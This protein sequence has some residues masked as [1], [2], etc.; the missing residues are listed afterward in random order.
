MESRFQPPERKEVENTDDVGA[1]KISSVRIGF[2]T[3]ATSPPPVPSVH[4]AFV[5]DDAQENTIEASLPMHEGSAALSHL[6]M[7][8]AVWRASSGMYTS[9]ATP[10]TTI[11]EVGAAPV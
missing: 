11:E 7:G 8:D 1:T 9:I 6:M 2:G 4:A 10:A 5:L 3:T